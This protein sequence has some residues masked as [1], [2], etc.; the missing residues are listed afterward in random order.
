MDGNDNDGGDVA[1]LGL[2]VISH[3]PMGH[4]PQG[5]GATATRPPGGH[6]MLCMLWVLTAYDVDLQSCL[7]PFLETPILLIP[8]SQLAEH[9]RELYQEQP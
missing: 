7:Y 5:R 9:A 2:M 8:P 3:A 4:H 6:K 1:V